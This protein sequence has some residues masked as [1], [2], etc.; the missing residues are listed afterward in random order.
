MILAL[1][2]AGYGGIAKSKSSL[3][4]TR[5]VPCLHLDTCRY[6]PIKT[7]KTSFIGD[8]EHAGPGQAHARA[9]P[10]HEHQRGVDT[11]VIWMCF[12]FE[13]T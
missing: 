5:S 7:I 6:N 11:S 10:A 4:L 3:H 12:T 9:L 2:Q 8:D 1:A 13:K